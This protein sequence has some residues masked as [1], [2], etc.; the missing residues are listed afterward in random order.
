MK[1]NPYQR[2]SEMYQ[3]TSICRL[4]SKLGLLAVVVAAGIGYSSS[5]VAVES[6][7]TAKKVTSSVGTFYTYSLTSL[8]DGVG[9]SSMSPGATHDDAWEHMWLADEG[10]V[11]GD[12]TFDFGS[13]YLID[14]AYVWNY[15]SNMN[16]TRGAKTVSLF[17]S[18]DGTNYQPVGG[19]Y[20]I[21]IGDGSPIA[22]TP[23]ALG[24]IDA[25]YVRLSILSNHG[26]DYMGL[27]EVHFAGHA[28]PE[29]ATLLLLIAGALG[30]AGCWT[31]RKRRKR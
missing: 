29:P 11:T 16:Y 19:I 23:I 20:T 30:P 4:I 25:R 5:A 10:N 13:R 1:S 18:V 22:G 14:T 12:L 27:S 7:L 24:G 6:F 15:N 8:T 2:G 9:L 26:D 21:P 31:W 3:E 17:K 28:V